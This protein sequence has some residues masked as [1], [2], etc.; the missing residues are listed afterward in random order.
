MDTI[1]QDGLRGAIQDIDAG[2]RAIR[3][4]LRKGLPVSGKKYLANIRRA[5][6]LQQQLQGGSNIVLAICSPLLP[7]PINP[8]FVGLSP[9]ERFRREW[10]IEHVAPVA[11][12]KAA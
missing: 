10:H 11:I 6:E 12:R 7:M 9:E 1:L 3:I 2:I 4:K 8:G 5:Y